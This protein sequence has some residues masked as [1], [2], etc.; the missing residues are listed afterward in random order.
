MVLFLL[1]IIAAIALGI[2]GAL[3]HAVWWLII[4]GA[5]V[6]LADLVYIGIRTGRGRRRVT[7]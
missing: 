3:L 5:V 2:V 4:I 1:V 6:L 7:R